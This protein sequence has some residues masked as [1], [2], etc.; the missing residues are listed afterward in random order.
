MPDLL[1]IIVPRHPERG[2]DV[3]ALAGGAPRRQLEQ[4]PQKRDHV[5][6]ADTLGELGLFF[7]L[8]TCVFMGN[9]LPGCKGGGHNPYEPARLGCAVSTGPL[10]GNFTE[11]YEHFGAAITTVADERALAAWVRRV[12]GHPAVRENLGD[13][14]REV[15]LADQSLVDRLAEQI[16]ALSWSC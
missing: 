14:A 6:V 8:A 1:T 13:A 3:A 15:A 4:I 12:V 16:L 2:A 7:S 10:T 11:A 9:S 5:W